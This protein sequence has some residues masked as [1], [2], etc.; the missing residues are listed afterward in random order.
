MESMTVYGRRSGS[1]STLQGETSGWM[2]MDRITDDLED[3]LDDLEIPMTMEEFNALPTEEQDKLLAA[4]QN[5]PVT[6]SDKTTENGLPPGYQDTSKLDIQQSA[7]Q[8]PD[9]VGEYD[10]EYAKNFSDKGAED[11]PI[12]VS[13]GA[14]SGLSG[15]VQP[16][17]DS[18]LRAG[19]QAVNMLGSSNV[20]SD[21]P[22]LMDD[23]Q[24]MPDF[25]REYFDS[26]DE[27]GRRWLSKVWSDAR[28]YEHKFNDINEL[29]AW[30]A[31]MGYPQEPGSEQPTI[32]YEVDGRSLNRDQVLEGIADG[33]IDPR[34][35]GVAQYDILGISGAD[36][37]AIKEGYGSYAGGVEEGDLTSEQEAERQRILDGVADGSLDTSTI[38]PEQLEELGLTP[39]DLVSGEIRE[40]FKEKTTKLKDLI[41]GGIKEATGASD[42]DWAIHENPTWDEDEKRD[43]SAITD[44]MHDLL[45]TSISLV[46]ECDTFDGATE[47][48]MRERRE[49]I[50]SG[51]NQRGGATYGDPSIFNPA[52]WGA[53][54]CNWKL[55]A[56][57]AVPIPG[58]EGGFEIDVT[59]DGEFVF[60]DKVK[61]EL[62]KVGTAI[63]DIPRRMGDWLNDIKEEVEDLGGE[64]QKAVLDPDG[65]LIIDIIDSAGNVIKKIFQ[66]LEGIGFDPD[67]AAKQGI[68][69]T[70]SRWAIGQIRDDF[71]RGVGLGRGSDD[72]RDDEPRYDEDGNLI[73]ENGN[74]ID[75]NGNRI[76]EN[77]NLLDSDGNVI[78]DDDDEDD[79]EDDDV[80]DDDGVDD[81]G[82]DDEEEFVTGTISRVDGSGDDQE[83]LVDGV[84]DVLDSG[85]AAEN[86]PDSVIDR[87]DVNINQSS[88]DPSD[89]LQNI[90]ASAA[91]ASAGGGGGGGLTGRVS[92][93]AA[94]EGGPLRY[95][96][97]ISGK[98]IFAGKRF[99]E[100]ENAGITALTSQYSE[101][102]NLLATLTPITGVPLQEREETAARG[103]MVRDGFIDELNSIMGY[104]RGR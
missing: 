86:L 20:G 45:G 11:D 3:F 40:W 13:F 88:Q 97:D 55:K 71:W 52:G 75:E 92:A 50:R 91:S 10:R 30:A 57:V 65:K 29:K 6:K 5:Q 64:I 60:D 22:T 81:D 98:S 23:T 73:D 15:D 82:V 54:G 58:L 69:T 2:G 103:G 48:E 95:F 14:D 1:G 67:V 87:R 33:S 37:E 56:R 104:G 72:G 90:L 99:T 68:G 21:V 51:P 9:K 49:A 96:V 47:E 4:I 53:P 61:E 16:S 94:E 85:G 76:D 62:G 102:D 59:E 17:F 93:T 84:I 31:S 36:L 78:D 80:V 89:I 79:D 43:A 42:E 35:I 28:A 34:L 25:M 101:L 24:G 46:H 77:G 70:L 8:Y 63:Q 74:L 44:I 83:V 39:D 27:E 32:Q 7:N 12:N 26:Q 41:V 66:P 100:E 38:T 18:R 19:A